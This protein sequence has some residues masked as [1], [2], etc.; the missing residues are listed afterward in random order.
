MEDTKMTKYYFLEEDFNI[1]RDTVDELHQK[2]WQLG[3][4]QAEA[5]G[6]STENFGHDDAVQEVIFDTRRVVLK[7]LTN[8][9][10]MVDHAQIIKPKGPFDKVVLGAKVKLS[11]GKTYMIGSF[12]IFADHDF[13][14]ISYQSPIAQ[15]IL[16]KQEGDEISFRGEEITILNIT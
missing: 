4:D 6:Q 5:S 3:K 14:N 9:S 16:G 7:Q 8:L 10:H 11:N 15:A 12:Q 13:E 2:I 1:L